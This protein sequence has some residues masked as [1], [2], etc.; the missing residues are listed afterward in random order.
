VENRRGNERMGVMGKRGEKE[1]R[2]K[3]IEFL[4]GKALK[5]HIFFMK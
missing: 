4:S 5:R 3:E 2:M 1:V